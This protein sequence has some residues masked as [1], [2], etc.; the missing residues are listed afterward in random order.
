MLMRATIYLAGF[1]KNDHLGSTR[2][3]QL[4][5]E[6]QASRSF[7]HITG[8]MHILLVSLAFRLLIGFR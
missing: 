2:L 4:I 6:E 8:T 1:L 5:P 7:S 3:P